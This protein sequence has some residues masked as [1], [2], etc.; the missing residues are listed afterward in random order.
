MN[1]MYM[2]SKPLSR[3]NMRVKDEFYVK[4]ELRKLQQKIRAGIKP[5]TLT[6]DW[7]YSD[8]VIEW[9][10]SLQSDIRRIRENLIY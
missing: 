8:T 10:N 6:V 5:Q 2:P 1:N 4:E 7:E 9:L 3:P